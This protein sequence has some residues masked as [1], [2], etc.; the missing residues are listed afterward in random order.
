ME[1]EQG[2]TLKQMQAEGR[3]Y[4]EAHGWYDIPRTWKEEIALLHSEASEALDAFRQWGTDDVTKLQVRGCRSV[5]PLD[6][7]HAAC[8]H[9]QEWNVCTAES[10]L[11]KPEGVGSE[12]ADV[13]I[14]LLD[15]CERHG[16]DIEEGGNSVGWAEPVFDDWPFGD[17]I[18]ELHGAIHRFG[19]TD[20]TDSSRDRNRYAALVYGHTRAICEAVG[21]DLDEEYERK[22]AFNLTRPYRHGNKRL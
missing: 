8:E 5:M 15:T 9:G 11:P 22:Y 3:A 14:R 6:G 10:P 17:M 7:P 4:S 19:I 2:K 21:I 16:I 18:T 20:L 12:L 13:L 1:T